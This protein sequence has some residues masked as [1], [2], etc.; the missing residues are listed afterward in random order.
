MSKKQT[1]VFFTAADREMAREVAAREAALAGERVPLA[2]IVRRLLRERLMYLKT[3]VG[4]E[5][6]EIARRRLDMMGKRVKS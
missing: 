4:G 3:T 6:M 1:A 2:R 5:D